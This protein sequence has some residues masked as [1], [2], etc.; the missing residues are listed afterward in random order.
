MQ[1]DVGRCGIDL[2]CAMIFLRRLA[3]LAVVLEGEDH[4]RIIPQNMAIFQMIGF[5][6]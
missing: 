2:G 6:D 3:A 4:E 5:G 1:L